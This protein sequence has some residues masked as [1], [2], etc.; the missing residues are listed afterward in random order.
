MSE[1][2]SEK[3]KKRPKLI[4][5]NGESGITI[6]KSIETPD[7]PGLTDTVDKS[8]ETQGRVQPC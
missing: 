5:I 4:E 1:K 7:E 8:I 2:M 3:F 6:D